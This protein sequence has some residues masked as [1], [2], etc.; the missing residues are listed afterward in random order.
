MSENEQQAPS[1]KNEKH[2]MWSASSWATWKQCPHKL[3][4]REQKWSRPGEK[5]D[6]R[7][8]VMAVP[9][10]VVDRLFELWLHRREFT[11][12][13]WLRENFDLVWEM[14][15]GKARPKWSSEEERVCIKGQTQRSVTI[16]Y[17]LLHEHQLLN[18]EMGIQT[19]FHEPVAE[20]ISVAGAIDLWT[21]R[22]NGAMVVLDFKNFGS[23]SHRSVDQLHFYA[24]ALKR[25]FGREP[26]EAGYVCFH[27][28]YAGY[29]KVALRQCDRNKLLSRIAKATIAKRSDEFPMK[30]SYVTCPR[31]CDVRFAC[32]K[33]RSVASVRL[34]VAAAK[35]HVSIG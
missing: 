3:F 12:T 23:N 34:Q 30:Y 18:K 26:E 21:V 11:N 20:G 9:G 17:K 8:A 33:F 16:L 31:F 35:N 10:L 27:P 1:S 5:R 4:L 2:I 32:E 29:R 19:E 14:V 25:V 6:S 7:M 13:A 22:P 24:M 15:V 28:A